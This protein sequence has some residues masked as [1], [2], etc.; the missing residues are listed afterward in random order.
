MSRAGRVVSGFGVVSAMPLVAVLSLSA[1]RP[2]LAACTGSVA[3]PSSSAVTIEC[4]VA[5]NAE[6]GNITVAPGDVTTYRDATTVN[7]GVTNTLIQFDGHGRTLDVGVGG[8]VTNN[9]VINGTTGSRNRTAVLI[10]AATQNESATT[11]FTSVAPTAGGN[12]LVT[13]SAAAPTPTAGWVGQTITFGH[14]N[15]GPGDFFPGSSAIITGVDT[16]N[17]T[18]TIQGTLPAN[19]GGTTGP[20]GLPVVFN[21][22]S[23]FGAGQ[24]IGGVFYNNVVRNAGTISAAIAA[25]E[26]NANRNGAASVSNT[27]Q[28][29]AIT[30][31][32]AGTYLVSN[33]STGVIRA[34][35]D[36]IGTAFAVEGGGTVTSLTVNNA[37]L[38][39][40]VRRADVVVNTAALSATANP[41]AT[42]PVSFAALTTAQTIGTVNAIN[43]Q[44]ELDSLVVNNAAGGIIRATGDWT[45]AIYSRAGDKQ[46]V[47]DGLIEH[48]SAAGDYTRGYAIVNHADN[49]EIRSLTLEN[50]GT[51][52]GDI[53]SVNGEALRYLLLSGTAT[54]DNRLNINPDY[55]P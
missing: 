50:H 34:T 42:S 5:P 54:P 21:V 15:A 13:L 32:V 14:F 9:R 28:V 37:G 39:E 44:E 53:L 12:T 27:G 47:N 36:G 35:H 51:I 19:F 8:A 4:G 6:I 45:G 3:A 33:A 55:A 49:N 46:I 30:S 52:H 38:I 31:N 22:T 41:T 7:P 10:G 11:T 17:K 29:R 16:V 18:V 24:T 40:A 1:S 25:S 23:N 48:L 43:T 26:I 20:A 2:A